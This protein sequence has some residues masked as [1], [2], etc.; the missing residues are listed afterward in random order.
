MFKVC[1]VLSVLVLSDSV[2]AGNHMKL[3]S[4]KCFVHNP[5]LFT[6]KKCYVKAISRDIG[7]F[8]LIADLKRPVNAPIYVNERYGIWLV[9]TWSVLD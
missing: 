1:F 6:L 3:V 7:T 8:N 2:L 9:L 4:L 5:E